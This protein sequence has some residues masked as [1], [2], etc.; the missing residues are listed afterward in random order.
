MD[1]SPGKMF[2]AG[3]TMDRIRAAA[4]AI[5]ETD[6]TILITGESGTGKE[7]LARYIHANGRR[8][9]RPF[10]AVN[11]AA[12]PGE[13]VES[14]LFGY[15]PGT[16]TGASRTGRKGKVESA[17]KGVLFLDEIGDMPFEA[18]TKILRIIQEKQV[19]RLGGSE[20]K[21]VDVRIIAATNQNIERKVH[22]NRFRLDLYYRLNVIPLAIP[23]L[24]ERRDE[25]E[26]MAD[27]FINIYNG[28]FDKK[29][30]GIADEVKAFFQN[31]PW[32]GNIRELRNFIEYAMNFLAEGAITLDCL[33]Q[34]FFAPQPIGF[35]IS[36]AKSLKLAEWET[37]LILE[38]LRRNEHRREKVKRAAGEL[39]IDYTTLYRKIKLYQLEEDEKSEKNG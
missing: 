10:I 21:E 38:A 24:R 23:P 27:Y 19:E 18:Q 14:E 37:A 31:Y 29:V 36:G 15:Q 1:Q 8:S 2:V 5:S 25:I 4:L 17:D 12:I 16:F 26:P 30:S 35:D 11:C 33:P 13:L 9:K 28:R 39:G 32:P 3:E 20:S 7:L 22:E 34:P 6:S